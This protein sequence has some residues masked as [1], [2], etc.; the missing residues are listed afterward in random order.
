MPLDVY[1]ATRLATAWL[2][3]QNAVPVER[4]LSRGHSHDGRAWKFRVHYMHPEY[5]ME[6]FLAQLLVKEDGSVAVLQDKREHVRKILSKPNGLRREARFFTAL[7]ARTALTPEWFL[8]VERAGSYVDVRGIDGFAHVKIG[9]KTLKMPFQIKSSKTNKKDF[10]A[11]YSHLP[12]VVEVIVADDWSTDDQ[13]RQRIYSAT[14]E[15]RSKILKG[16]LTIAGYKQQV[17]TFF[18]AAR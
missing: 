12:K 14:G 9:E 6:F 13:L 7:E 4:T 1:S 3:E 5:N 15:V 8:K 2:S 16:N 17:T 10:L 18:Q 11:K